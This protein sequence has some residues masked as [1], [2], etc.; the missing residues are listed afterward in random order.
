MTV[1][2]NGTIPL[3]VVYEDE[4]TLC[5]LDHE[6]KVVGHSLIIPKIEVDH[7]YDVP[8]VYYLAVY[9]TAYK[10]GPIYQQALESCRVNQSVSGY[11][12][13][14]FHLHLYP[15]YGIFPSFPPEHI[16]DKNNLDE[17]CQLLKSAIK[18]FH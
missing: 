8:E 1:K 5:F 6:P 12:V 13:P 11:H 18:Q 16:L 3:H 9:S 14:H 7:Y 2:F 4:L 15:S 10:L 17:V